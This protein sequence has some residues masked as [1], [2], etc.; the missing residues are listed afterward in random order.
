MRANLVSP[1][2]LVIIMGIA[3]W[4]GRAIRKKASL[5]QYE[6]GRKTDEE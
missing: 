2:V 1:S 3:L 4:R 5:A 6:E